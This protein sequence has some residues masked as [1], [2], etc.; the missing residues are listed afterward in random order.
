V[1][2]LGAVSLL[3]RRWTRRRREA[4]PPAAVDAAMSDRI[5]REMER[6]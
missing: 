2:G 1:V 6:E 4:A 3:L 5:R